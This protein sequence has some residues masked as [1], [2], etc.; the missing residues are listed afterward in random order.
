[1]PHAARV[2]VTRL[3]RELGENA[4]LQRLK[5]SRSTLY[6]LMAG[7]SVYAGTRALIEQD[8]EKRA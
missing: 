6:R 3:F 2:H 4:T 1:M 8:M 7:L 5:V